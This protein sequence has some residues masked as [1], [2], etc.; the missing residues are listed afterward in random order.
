VISIKTRA[1]YR[2]SFRKRG[3]WLRCLLCWVIGCLVISSD[4]QT[5]YDL[6]FQMR[7]TK[8]Q[9]S[10]IVLIT[11][12]QSDVAGIFSQ[13]GQ[14][15]RPSRDISDITDSFFWDRRTWHTTIAKLLAAD[16]RNIGVTFFF[17]DNLPK[18]NFR[19]KKKICFKIRK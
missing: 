11:I 14:L 18:L 1:L 10:E 19:R 12:R 2:F 13:R 5:S 8:T 17:G 16:V 3:F 15:L 6:R 4:E 7:G 9:A